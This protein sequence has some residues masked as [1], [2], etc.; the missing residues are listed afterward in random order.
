MTPLDAQNQFKGSFSHEF[1]SFGKM[2]YFRHFLCLHSAALCLHVMEALRNRIFVSPGFTLASNGVCKLFSGTPSSNGYITLSFRNPVTGNVTSATV[3][4]V[5]TMLH[6]GTLDLPRELDASHLCH[7]KT[8]IVLE[9]ISME[10]RKINSQRRRCV[11]EG[12]CL[13]HG[14]YPECMLHLHLSQE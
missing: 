11:M 2:A 10:P 7:N 5:V 13:G 3:Q 4:R 8:C 9:H 14:V 1:V 12:Q 6:R